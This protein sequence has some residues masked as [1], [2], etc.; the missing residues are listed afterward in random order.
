MV[1]GGRRAKLKTKV[2]ARG[3]DEDTP[4]LPGIALDGIL[5]RAGSQGPDRVPDQLRRREFPTTPSKSRRSIGVELR[6][7][8]QQTLEFEFRAEI[9]GEAAGA[10]SNDHDFDAL[11]APGFDRVTQL[12][13]LLTTEESTEMS[14]ED[15]HDHSVLP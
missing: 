2:P 5:S 12:R 6:I 14:Q 1:P 10:V 13:D 7:D 4:E 8:E 11:V 15:Q 3:K 9:L